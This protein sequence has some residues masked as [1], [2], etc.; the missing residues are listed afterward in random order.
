MSQSHLENDSDVENI[1]RIAVRIPDPNREV[2][3]RERLE[4]SAAEL[5]I[6]PEQLAEAEKRYAEQK[7]LEADMAAYVRE[8]RIGFL[9]HLIPYLLVNSFAIADGLKDGS[10]G[11]LFMTL[12][13]GTGLF[14][15]GLGVF[16]RKSDEFQKEFL[17]W[18]EKR[19]HKLARPH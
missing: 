11:F 17:E 8:A 16:N 18:R 4:R 14:F 1:L 6:T 2:G 9:W 7:A 19:A 5:E 10:Y 13:W 12:G 15:H 3:L